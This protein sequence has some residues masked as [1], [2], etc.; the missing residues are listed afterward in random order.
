M[1]VV[2]LNPDGDIQYAK[3]SKQV[4]QMS[5]PVYLPIPSQRLDDNEQDEHTHTD[6]F[7]PFDNASQLCRNDNTYTMPTESHW[8][9][10]HE[11][12][13]CFDKIFQCKEIEQWNELKWHWPLISESTVVAGLGNVKEISLEFTDD[14]EREW[15]TSLRFVFE[16]HRL[17]PA[18]MNQ[19]PIYVHI[20]YN[21]PIALDTQA[22]A[23]KIETA[24]LELRQRTLRGDIAEASWGLDANASQYII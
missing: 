4:W 22:A 3:L 8:Q 24:M 16:I 9:F 15:N 21:S 5:V 19:W 10:V 14:N 17:Q 6:G 20:F 2:T 13:H 7:W 23:R 1:P 11:L 18:N 12:F